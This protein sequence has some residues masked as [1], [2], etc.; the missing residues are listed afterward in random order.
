MFARNFSFLSFSFCCYSDVKEEY[1]KNEGK[2]VLNLEL[3]R[4]IKT[5]NVSIERI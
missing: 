2:F 3:S 1:N 5:K 4:K